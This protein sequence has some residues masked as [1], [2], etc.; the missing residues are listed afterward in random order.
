[1]TQAISRRDPLWAKM[2]H[3][4]LFPMELSNLNSDTKDEKRES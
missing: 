4:D 2:G 1:M 3:E